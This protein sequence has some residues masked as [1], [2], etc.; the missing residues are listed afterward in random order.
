MARGGGKARAARYFNKLAQARKV[1][2]DPRNLRFQSV[3]P[4]S[5]QRVTQ[6]FIS[7]APDPTQ[8]IKEVLRIPQLME[9]FIEPDEEFEDEDFEEEEEEEY[10]D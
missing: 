1:E 6:P 8:R 10:F 2:Q 7:V 3:P 9:P 5:V 4:L